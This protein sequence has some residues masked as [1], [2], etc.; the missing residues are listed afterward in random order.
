[1]QAISGMHL[2]LNTNYN[3]NSTSDFFM[4]YIHVNN[5]SN[6]PSSIRHASAKTVHITKQSPSNDADTGL[7]D[8]FSNYLHDIED[9]KIKPS[10]TLHNDP[11]SLY[12]MPTDNIDEIERI[13]ITTLAAEITLHP[14]ENVAPYSHIVLPHLPIEVFELSEIIQ[15]SPLTMPHSLSSDHAEDAQITLKEQ[16]T[17]IDED[18]VIDLSNAQDRRTQNI[19]NNSKREAFEALSKIMRHEAKLNNVSISATATEHPIPQSVI[20]IPLSALTM[21]PI[22]HALF[23]Q[24]E[25]SNPTLTMNAI[26]AWHQ[27]ERSL[28]G[29]SHGGDSNF[30]DSPEQ[31]AKQ[32][33]AHAEETTQKADA[34]RTIINTLHSRINREFNIRNTNISVQ[35]H[36]HTLGAVDMDLTVD[37]GKARLIFK[38]EKKEM[39]RLLSQNR[40]S[41]KLILVDADLEVSPDA[42]QILP[43]NTEQ[44]E[45]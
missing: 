5:T 2:A 14:P 12:I 3:N 10:K 31:E 32:I 34:I 15:P 29:G 42:I 45:M 33:I 40:E 41:I 7:Q 30:R 36:H 1:M 43:K 16:T 8:I 24:S 26:P 19:A 18:T 20:Q 37:N 21:H 17:I 38:G 22:E 9:E 6:D 39:Q 23:D 13:L 11:R 4:A 27:T 25:R 35:M 28:G 44:Q